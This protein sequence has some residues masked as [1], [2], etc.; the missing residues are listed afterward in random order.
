MLR[1]AT[2]D[3]STWPRR[4]R[5]TH[6]PVVAAVLAQIVMVVV[7]IGSPRA[8]AA[9]REDPL[10]IV[11]VITDDQRAGT[12]TH[13]PRLRRRIAER[14]VRFRSAF[15]P[16]PSCC[17]SRASFLTGTYS[18]TNGVWKNG[19]PFG[20]FAA[21]DPSSTIATWLDD[22]G[23]R[24]G[25]FGKYLNGYT[26]ASIVPPGWD[27]WFGFLSGDG[28]SYYGFN[29]SVNGE[30][31]DF[32]DDE[33]STT[34][35]SEEVSRFIRSTPADRPLFALWTPVA[36]HSPAVPEAAY[37]DA[38]LGLEPW[39]PPN[40]NERDVSDK[41]SWLRRTGR[42]DAAQRLA[43]DARRLDQYRT[44]LSVDDGIADIVKSLRQ[45]GRLS[46]T[47]I[48]FASDNGVMWGEHRLIRKAAPF[49]GA[50]HVPMLVRYDPLTAQGRGG[51]SR[52]LVL[53]LDVAPTIAELVRLV[54]PTAV[55]GRSLVP[56]LDGSAVHVRKRFVV[57]H[58]DGGVPAYCGARTRDE[59]FVHY[60]GGDEEY[61]RLDD[62]PY[63][64]ENLIDDRE[65]RREI[66]ALRRYAR[67][68]CD[69][70]PPGFSW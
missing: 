33:Y 3:A 13:M 15:I 30:L 49:D 63:S 69:P 58:A 45:S 8:V 52:S 57:E 44:L 11:L 1:T 22:A 68:Q 54:P 5:A 67:R 48:V 14:G 29:A 23:Y 35:S 43:I 7:V 36:P 56:L 47:L 62:D 65:W 37:V 70:V 21:F 17:P 61:Y 66:A 55:D 6:L 31:V 51:A 26:D 40:F 16:N 27:A 18:H 25:L 12:L 38:S 9:Q 50:S 20:G 60:V 41:S 64:L 32:A 39:R 4:R 10:D 2:F 19:G 59:L 24:T 42:L 34:V 46:N 53:N 28:R